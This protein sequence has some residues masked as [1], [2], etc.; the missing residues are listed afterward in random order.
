MK[1][2][3]DRALCKRS[4]I[5][6]LSVIYDFCCFE[7]PILLV[8]FIVPICAVISRRREMDFSLF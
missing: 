3:G 1:I 6:I 2:Y 4:V 7:I 8:I 5:P